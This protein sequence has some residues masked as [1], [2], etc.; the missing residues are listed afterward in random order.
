M[1]DDSFTQKVVN[2]LVLIYTPG[3]PKNI[4][5]PGQP[6]PGLEPGPLD[7]ESISLTIR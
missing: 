3:L 2:S 7:P 1:A 5:R 4:T 6:G